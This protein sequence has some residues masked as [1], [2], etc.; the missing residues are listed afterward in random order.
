MGTSEL[1]Y[2]W[3]AMIFLCPCLNIFV[4]CASLRIIR[5]LILI[6]SYTRIMLYTAIRFIRS[7]RLMHEVS[8]YLCSLVFTAVT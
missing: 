3:D 2:F 1:T 8:F 4:S 7:N 6:F 5:Q